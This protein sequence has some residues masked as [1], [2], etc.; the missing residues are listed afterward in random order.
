MYQL[1]NTNV[2][3]YDTVEARYWNQVCAPEQRTSAGR[4]SCQKRSKNLLSKGSTPCILVPRRQSSSCLWISVD[5]FTISG[6]CPAPGSSGFGKSLSV[7]DRSY[8]APKAHHT[9]LFPSIEWL[10]LTRRSPIL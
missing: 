8:M 9:A 10:M 3:H 6:S 7:M 5:S 2:S 1:H 4:S